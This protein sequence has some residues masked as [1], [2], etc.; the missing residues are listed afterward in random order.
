MCHIVVL[1][2]V[3]FHQ[4]G[5]YPLVNWH[6]AYSPNE[7][8]LIFYVNIQVTTHSHLLS[9]R[10]LEDISSAVNIE[11]CHFSLHAFDTELDFS[12][13]IR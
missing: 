1:S 8:Y 13:R 5:M 11:G 10:D 12:N 7:L 2:V 6:M 4:C 3:Y 9:N